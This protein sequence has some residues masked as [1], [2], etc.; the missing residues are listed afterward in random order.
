MSYVSVDEFKKYS[1]VYEESD[2][3]QK[4]VDSAENIVN[5]YLGY[6]PVLHNYMSILNGTGTSELQLKARPIRGITGIEINEESVPVTEL[7]FDEDS[8]FIYFDKIFPSGKRNVK[9][10]YSAGYGT[11]PDSDLL[12]GELLPVVIRMSV[13]R[14]AALLQSEGDSNIGVTSKSFADS[15]TRTFTNFTNFDKYLSPISFYK[16]VVI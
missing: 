6:S 11:V 1:N 16:L 8:E 13:L 3:Q 14:I 2:I 7:Y 9:V 15:G 5:N 10:Q 4:Y 12:N